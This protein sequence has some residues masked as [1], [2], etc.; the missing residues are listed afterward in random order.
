MQE[1]IVEGHVSSYLPEGRSW[2]LIW[3]DEFD[4]TELDRTKWDLRTDYWG[5]PAEAYT[6]QGVV[7]DGKGNVELHRVER[8]GYYVSPQLQTGCNSFDVPLGDGKNTWKNTKWPLGD[9]SPAKSG[10]NRPQSVHPMILPGAAWKTI[11][12]SAS[13]RILPLPA[14]SSAAMAIR[15]A[16]KAEC[17]TP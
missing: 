2:K 1:Y 10:C 5:K 17:S 11:L 9:L 7:L 4:G 16:R 6:D 12:W 13:I 8:D 14:I 15:S 3:A